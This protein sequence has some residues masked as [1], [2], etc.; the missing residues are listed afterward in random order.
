MRIPFDLRQAAIGYQYNILKHA[1]GFQNTSRSFSVRSSSGS[2]KSL[3]IGTLQ[4]YTISTYSSKHD[5]TG[6]RRYSN[7]AVSSETV[8]VVG[9]TGNIGVSAVI[10]SLRSG[11]GVLAIVRNQASAEKLFKHVGSKDG[12]TTV[13]ADVTSETGVQSVVDQVKAGK[14]PAFQHVYST[15][16]CRLLP[17]HS[18]HVAGG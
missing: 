8:L 5:T 6:A 10:G 17:L 13:E 4:P 11:R 7:R 14:L 1:P 16:M 9:A 3:S 2:S 12:I 15:S 18:V